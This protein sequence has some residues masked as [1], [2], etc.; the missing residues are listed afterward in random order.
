M[1]EKKT[2]FCRGH[3]QSEHVRIATSCCCRTSPLPQKKWIL[4]TTLV[5]FSIPLLNINL[6]A[7]RVSVT[8]MS[9]EK[10]TLIHTFR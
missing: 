9:E 3:W 2:Y 1:G 7:A 6:L 8:K 4:Q 5:C 10:L